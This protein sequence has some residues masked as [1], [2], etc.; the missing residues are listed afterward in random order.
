MIVQL[1][2]KTYNIVLAIVSI[3]Q[4]KLKS[5][6]ASQIPPNSHAWGGEKE[7]IFFIDDLDLSENNTTTA[8]K[9]I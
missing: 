1:F 3:I 9:R 8:N 2:K 7:P 6:P 5:K 4:L